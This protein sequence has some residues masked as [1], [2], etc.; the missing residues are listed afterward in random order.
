MRRVVVHIDRLVLTGL[1]AAAARGLQAR[2]A[3]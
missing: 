2:Q 1:S 3:A